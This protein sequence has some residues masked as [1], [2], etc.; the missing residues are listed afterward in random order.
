[1][2]VLRNG[3]QLLPGMHLK[4]TLLQN[5]IQAGQRLEFNM[6]WY[7]TQLPDGGERFYCKPGNS[8]NGRSDVLAAIFH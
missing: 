4:P 2:R 3:S 6:Q 1:M 7:L 5:S 8:N